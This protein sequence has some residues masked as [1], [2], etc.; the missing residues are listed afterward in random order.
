M[1][2]IVSAIILTSFSDKVIDFAEKSQVWR[3]GEAEEDVA[4][5]EGQEEQEV[6]EEDAILGKI[7][8][9]VSCCAEWQTIVTV[10]PVCW[11][12]GPFMW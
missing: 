12:R 7:E 9:D 2:L 10:G 3:S 1:F 11:S 6:V 8:S 4:E 5:A